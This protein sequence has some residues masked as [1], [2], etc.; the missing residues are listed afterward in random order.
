[1]TR[2][3]FAFL[4]LALG[5]CASPAP[6]KDLPP[7][8]AVGPERLLELD[9]GAKIPT[10]VL[11][12]YGGTERSEIPELAE[13]DAAFVDGTSEAFGSR[14]AA[15]EAAVEIGFR[16]YDVNDFEKAMRRFNQGWL[17]EPENPKVFMGY[18][19]VYNDFGNFG[20]AAGFARTSLELGLRDAGLMADAAFILAKAEAGPL[21]A[22]RVDP[23]GRSLD[24][25]RDEVASIVER[26]KERALWEPQRAYVHRVGLMA[27]VTVGNGE[28]A[29]VSHDHL[30][31]LGAE[32]PPREFLERLEALAPRDGR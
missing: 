25:A 5:A 1:M 20:E 10:N 26:A 28:A 22:P 21:G 32:M 6:R 29:R 4:L 27:H 31:E 23:S 30:V 11:P 7:V 15:C 12:M 17:L 18:A 2:S 9:P 14:H 19:V 8:W 16:A 3:P 13:V 24:A